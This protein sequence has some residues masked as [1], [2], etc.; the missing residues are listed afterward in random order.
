[1]QHLP[2][3]L[4]QPDDYSAVVN[5]LLYTTARLQK[6]ISQLDTF[7]ARSNTEEE[8]TYFYKQFFDTVKLYDQTVDS[9]KLSIKLTL[10]RQR[11]KNVPRTMSYYR[12]LKKI[13]DYK[14][15]RR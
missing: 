5:S 7:I 12:L 14:V 4:S 2:T 10:E 8:K 13:S 1:M 11:L 9:L 15:S 6:T 3:K